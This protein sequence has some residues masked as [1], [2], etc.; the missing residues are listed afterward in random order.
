MAIDKST[1]LGYI[2]GFIGTVT[3]VEVL[4]A[5]AL[6]FVGAFGGWLFEKLKR[7]YLDKTKDRKNG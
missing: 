6:G 5:L 4:T 7:K 3:F 2:F 1:I